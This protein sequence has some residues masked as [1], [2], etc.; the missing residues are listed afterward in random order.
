MTVAQLI[1]LLQQY[2]RIADGTDHGA[3]AEA[4]RK[5]GETLASA[6][7]LK[8]EALVRRL[9]ASSQFRPKRT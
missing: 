2:A 3:A 5:L 1:A 9:E 6:S 8:V 7:K 4:A